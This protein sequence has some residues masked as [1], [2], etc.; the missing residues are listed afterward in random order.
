[1]KLPLGLFSVADEYGGK[2]PNRAVF[3]GEE[4]GI[5]PPFDILTP[6]SARRSRWLTLVL[7]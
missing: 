6:F 5:M 1:M 2:L 3:F 4:L 7:I